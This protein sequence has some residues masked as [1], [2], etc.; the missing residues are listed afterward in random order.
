MNGQASSEKAHPRRGSEHAVF[1]DIADFVIA[2]FEDTRLSIPASDGPRD[3]ARLADGTDNGECSYGVTDMRWDEG[4]KRLHKR[5]CV[6]DPAL[7]E[8]AEVMFF[9][10]ATIKLS[11]EERFDVRRV[12]EF[13]EYIKPKNGVQINGT[14]MP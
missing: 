2:A 7:R 5:I 9:V 6:D 10:E 13:L 1:G 4:A 3:A 14:P 11:Q 8:T 12:N